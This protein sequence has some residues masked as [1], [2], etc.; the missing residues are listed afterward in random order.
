MEGG[1]ATEIELKLA[2][3]R[4]DLPALRRALERRAAS[5]PPGRAR[6]VSTYF[7]TPDRRLASQGLA[8]RVR[9]S[10]GKFVQTVK[11]AQ[12][13][14]PSDGPFGMVRGEWEDAVRGPAPDREATATGHF[15]GGDIA[16]RL[17]PLFRTEIVRRRV[18]LA[19]A[20]DTRIEAAIDRGRIC[21]PARDTVEPVSELELEL[22][23]GPNSALY[24]VALDLL[25]VAPLRL[26][27]RSKAE[28]GD[29][30]AAAAT[31]V[32]APAAPAAVHATEVRLEPGLSG[33]VALRRIGIAC[34]DQLR[35]NEPAVLAGDPEGLHQMRVAV[36]RLRAILSAFGKLLP[37]GPRREASSELRWLSDAL[38]RA[39]NLDVFAQ[40]LLPPVRRALTRAEGIA[41]LGGAVEGLRLAAYAKAKQA[42]LSPRYTGLLLRLLR[43][44][45][46]CGW[47]EGAGSPALRQPIEGIAREVLDRRRKVA[48]RRSR[49]FAKQSAPERHRL[50]IA[51]K[52][53]RYAAE[54]LAALYDPGEVE[55][56]VR[57]L[58]R[59]QDDLGDA[60]DLRVG[61]DI[62]AELVRSRR[63]PGAIAAAGDAVLEWHEHRLA[64]HAP[65][66]RLHL[67]GLLAAPPFWAG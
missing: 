15:I 37:A 3:R 60:N 20:P 21:A 59:L 33:D 40:T 23:S 28:R 31:V 35:R 9:A 41:L 18:A 42:V 17:V 16:G 43:W 56:F 38:G 57:R 62:V 48:Q 8:L 51:L 11:S 66:V 14:G 30:L 1:I 29:A 7:D 39:R 44:F 25:T 47:Q 6:L 58:K 52:K 61:R 27:W 26:D 53:L 45:D 19:P 22:K 54:L 63:R 24:D 64:N 12:G 32:F 13:D 5:G 67:D 55:G 46:S 2:A 49:G 50:R 34:L 36:R 10:N 4:R 65:R